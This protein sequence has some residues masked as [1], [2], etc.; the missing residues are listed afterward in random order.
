MSSDTVGFWLE[1]ATRTPLLS[2]EQEITLGRDIQEW[3]TAEDPSPQLVRRGQRAK[4]RMI[5]S[6]LRLV[7]T[8]A[9]KFLS[10]IR[11]N[12]NLQQEDLLQE[13]IFGLNRAAEKFDPESGYKFSTYSYWW[14]RQAMQRVVEQQST[15]IRSSSQATQIHLRWRY[16]P[17]GQTIEEFAKSLG[18]DVRQVQAYL[19]AFMQTQTVSFDGVMMAGENSTQRLEDILSADQPDNDDEYAA[20]LDELKG[21]DEIKDSLAILELS[22]EASKTDLSV[23]LECTPKHVGKKLKD[24]KSHVREHMPSDLRARINGEEVSIPVKI[25]PAIP[26][27]EQ[28]PAKELALINCCSSESELMPEVSTNGHHSLE[29]E[30]VAVINE[31]QEVEAPKPPRKRRSSAEVAAT[32]TV[33][34]EINGMAMKGKAADVAAVLKAYTT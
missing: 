24:V 22:E 13:G 33:E 25:R 6:N 34:L 8:L 20:I 29:A 1:A 18:R 2:T 26:K 27:P 17:E 9:K 30:A 10:R 11:Y 16:R 14:I 32:G 15:T 28:L 12:P 23:L 4:D 5:K 31:V 19:D 3:M 21:I 7:S